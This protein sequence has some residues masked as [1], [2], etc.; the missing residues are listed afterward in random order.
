MLDLRFVVPDLRRL[1]E[2][3]AEV[4]VSC[5]WKDERPMQGLSS[6]VDWRLAGRL[7]QLLRQGF[8][9]GEV[10]E[11]LI[12]PVRHKLRFDNLLVCGLGPRSGFDDATFR[13][14]LGRM[15]DTLAGLLVKKAVVQL[16]GRTGDLFDSERAAEI[17]LDLAHDNVH[18]ALTL[19]EDIDGQKRIERRVAEQHRGALCIRRGTQ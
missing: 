14:V 3:S 10:G 16:P 8:L 18:D 19:V 12:V 5:I 2:I 9:V 11:V 6:L 17:L 7:S 4:I 1:D 15:L 13:R